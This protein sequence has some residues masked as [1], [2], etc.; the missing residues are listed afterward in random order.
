MVREA[1]QSQPPSAVRR[2][3]HPIGLISDRW[4]TWASAASFGPALTRLPIPR[5]GAGADS[6][7]SEP[8]AF[9]AAGASS[10][11]G[12]ERRQRPRAKAA[13][14]SRQIR[15]TLVV[16]V[17]AWLEDGYFA[18]HTRVART[19]R[20]ISG[21]GP[22]SRQSGSE[23]CRLRRARIVT[24]RND[25]RVRWRASLEELAS[26]NGQPCAGPTAAQV[27]VERLATVDRRVL[28]RGARITAALLLLMD[29][30]AGCG[31]APPPAV[32]PI[33]RA[34]YLSCPNDNAVHD[35]SGHPGGYHN[36]GWK[37]AERSGGGRR[38]LHRL[39]GQPLDNTVIA[40]D[41]R[42]GAQ[43]VISAE[44]GTHA[45]TVAPPAA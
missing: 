30:L 35:R 27:G 34:G 7:S 32:D 14:G 43:T 24:G 16:G 21:F 29:P 41:T 39:R 10:G 2:R 22:V 33:S 3:H 15:T 31:G 26:W 45:V 20:G 42:T 12:R 1:G 28:R 8:E 17:R 18:T 11:V 44:G 5:Y 23:R 36:P 9:A 25:W 40:I 4:A 6:G 13:G 38:C 37:N 19:R